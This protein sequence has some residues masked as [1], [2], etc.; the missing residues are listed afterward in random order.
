M[1]ALGNAKIDRVAA[2]TAKFHL[3]PVSKHQP[4]DG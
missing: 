3:D 2:L 1:V 4:A